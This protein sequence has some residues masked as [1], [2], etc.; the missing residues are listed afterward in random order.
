MPQM[1]PG[2]EAE[3]VMDQADMIMETAERKTIPEPKELTLAEIEE[4]LGYPIRITNTNDAKVQSETLAGSE[5]PNKLT[6]D[7]NELPAWA[8]W[9]ARDAD[10]D[11]WVYEYTPTKEDTYWDPTTGEFNVIDDGLSPSVKWTDPQPTK[12]VRRQPQ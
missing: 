2:M 12:I 8:N 4:L 9:V 1:S 10:G 5:E 3:A 7:T 11:L 6:I